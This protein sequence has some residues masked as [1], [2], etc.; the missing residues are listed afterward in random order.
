MTTQSPL[1]LHSDRKE[2]SKGSYIW[3]YLWGSTVCTFSMSM[4]LFFRHIFLCLCFISRILLNTFAI[5][6]WDCAKY[7]QTLLSTSLIYTYMYAFTS[8]IIFDHHR[9]H[10]V[11]YCIPFCYVLKFLTK[12]LSKYPGWLPNNSLVNYLIPLS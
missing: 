3:V 5:V 2:K 4:F 1:I 7:V 12:L 6:R 11:H 9:K 10:I 8:Y